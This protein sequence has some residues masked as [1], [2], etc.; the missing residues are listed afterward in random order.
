MAE[1]GLA[2]PD[3]VTVGNPGPDWGGKPE[4]VTILHQRVAHGRT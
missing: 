1:C 4:T 3:R 2:V